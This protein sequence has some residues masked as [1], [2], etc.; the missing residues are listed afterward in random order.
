MPFPITLIQIEAREVECHR[1]Q[2]DH[3]DEATGRPIV[4]TPYGTREEALEVWS[5]RGATEADL[6]TTDAR[7]DA[8]RSLLHEL[9][10]A[11]AKSGAPGVTYALAEHD[12]RR[13]Q[14]RLDGAGL[15]LE[16]VTAGPADPRWSHS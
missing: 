12:F 10:A 13:A 14:S 5:S 8:I 6:I 4:S 3:T 11:F 15:D 1:V 16:F 7:I 9:E 2:F